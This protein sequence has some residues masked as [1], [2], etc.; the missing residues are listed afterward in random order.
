MS[1][2]VMLV[3]PSW[4]ST[5]GRLVSWVT[6]ETA[7]HRSRQVERVDVGKRRR[8]PDPH[9]TLVTEH[10]LARIASLYGYLNRAEPD[11]GH[12]GFSNP[13]CRWSCLCRFAKSVSAMW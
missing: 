10:R 1:A 5:A 11:H 4:N 7:G 2:L 12:V 9:R 8:S 3:R 13:H 6:W